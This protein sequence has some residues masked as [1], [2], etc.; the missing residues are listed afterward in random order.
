MDR[1]LRESEVRK[2]LGGISRTTLWEWRRNGVFPQP[3]KIGGGLH[4]WR[5]SVLIEWLDSRPQV[6]ADGHA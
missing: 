5:E 2:I 1:I 6:G 3:L 4:G